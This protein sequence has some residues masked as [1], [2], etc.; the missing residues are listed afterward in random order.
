MQ[1]RVI[2]LVLGLSGFVAVAEDAPQ[3]RPVQDAELRRELLDRTQTDQEARKALIQWMNEHGSNGLVD[4]SKLSKEKQTEYE[5]VFARMVRVDADNTKWLKSVVEK[6]GWPRTSRVGADG[7]K[8]AWLLVQHA[9][10]DAKFQRRCLDL[11]TAL[12][13]SEVSQS[14]LAYLTDRVLLAEGKKQLY[15]TQFTSVD[16][17]W[18]PRPIE[19]EANVDKRRAAAGLPPLAEYAERM[20]QQ[21]GGRPKK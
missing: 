8:S 2:L 12:P 11:M 17:R 20:R 18:Q 1:A 5:K 10:A 4:E 16:G 6:H 13:K 7:A 19:E 3:A 21:Y 14:N 15:G 9:D